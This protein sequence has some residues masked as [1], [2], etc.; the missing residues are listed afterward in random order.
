MQLFNYIGGIAGTGKSYQLKA[1]N[2]KY[3][4]T[5]VLTATT[6]VAAIN[7]GRGITINSLLWYFNHSDLLDSWTSGKLDYRL[8]EVYHKLGIRRILLDEV[9]MLNADDL[10]ILCLAIDRLNESLAKKDRQLFGMTLCGDFAQLPPIEGRFAFE[11]EHWD[12]FEDNT[13]ILH[14]VYRQRDPEFIQALQWVREGE[15]KKAAEYFRDVMHKLGD[16]AFDGTTLYPYNSS[17][18]RQNAYRLGKVQGGTVFFRASRSG[19]QRPE[20]KNVPDKLQLKHSSL[21]MILANRTE[22]GEFLYCNG[23]LGYLVEKYEDKAKVELQRNGRLVDVKFVTRKN[24]E[25]RNDEKRIVG[26]INYMPL[27]LAYASTIH[28]SQGLTLDAVQIDI[29]P[30]FYRECAGMLYV[31]LSRARTKSGLR[32]LGSPKT[33]IQQCVVNPK[34]K[35]FL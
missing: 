25:I 5:T 29:R 6:G 23:D 22:E 24:T 16:P 35:R 13:E 26:E 4:E 18:D 1:L 10:S 7:M 12:K 27:R 32:M 17:V 15:G 8:G 9:S 11:S 3:P 30:K 31:G 19:K 2:D 14:K 33:F 21:V 34:I 20:W 28:K